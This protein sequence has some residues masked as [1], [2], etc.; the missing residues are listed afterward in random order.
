MFSM[1]YPKCA[2]T[3]KFQAFLRIKSTLYKNMTV[4]FWLLYGLIYCY[5]KFGP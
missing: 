1:I 2:A 4:T 3:I 5:M